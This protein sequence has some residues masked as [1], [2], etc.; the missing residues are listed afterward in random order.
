MYRSMRLARLRLS[1]FCGAVWTYYEHPPIASRRSH[2]QSRPMLISLTLNTADDI[3]YQLRAT[4]EGKGEGVFATRHFQVGE[5]VMVG[6]I[7]RRVT[8]NHSHATQISR[9]EYVE[10][11][12][13]AP[14]VNHSCSPNC[15]VRLNGSGAYDLVARKAIAPGEEITFDYAMRNYSI[16]Y[17]PRRC[18]CGA[19][20]CRGSVTGWKDLPDE[21]KRAYQGLVAPYLLEMDQEN[22]SPELGRR[23]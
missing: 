21:R 1:P 16:E 20:N 3:G 5:T 23:E 4:P 13:L 7:E 19:R 17:F 22:T 9:S 6:V 18:L 14:K 15:G 2:R 11:A 10:L 8:E 12:G